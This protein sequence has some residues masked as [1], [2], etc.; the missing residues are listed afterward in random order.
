[1][2][3]MSIKDK[4]KYITDEKGAKTAVVVPL[5]KWKTMSENIEE[6]EAYIQL[7]NSLNQGIKEVRE[8]ESGKVEGKSLSSFLN[9]L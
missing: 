4:I 1:M 3:E 5:S 8:I 6:F 2:N 9:E 7:K